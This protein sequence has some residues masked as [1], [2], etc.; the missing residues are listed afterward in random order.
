MISIIAKE[1]FSATEYIRILDERTRA[2]VGVIEMAPNAIEII[3]VKIVTVLLKSKTQGIL[4]NMNR[5]RENLYKKA[6]AQF[7]KINEFMR[8]AGIKCNFQPSGDYIVFDD[9]DQNPLNTD[10]PFFTIGSDKDGNRQVIFQDR[11]LVTP[12]EQEQYFAENPFDDDEMSNKGTSKDYLVDLFGRKYKAL[13]P[14]STFKG[15]MFFISE[16]AFV[17]RGGYTLTVPI[18]NQEIAVFGSNIDDARTYAHELG[19][20]LGLQHPFID[21]INFFNGSIRDVLNDKG[22]RYPD[23]NI[24]TLIRINEQNIKDIEE[25]IEKK[26]GEI[27][28]ETEQNKL[29][30][31]NK[32]LSSL[33]ERKGELLLEKNDLEKRKIFLEYRYNALFGQKIKTRIKTSANIMDYLYTTQE[34]EANPQLKED[35]KKKVL[36]SKKQCEIMRKEVGLY[37]TILPLLIVVFSLFSNI[38]FGQEY[39]DP[40]SQDKPIIVLPDILIK[41]EITGNKMKDTII[42]TNTSKGTLFSQGEKSKNPATFFKTMEEYH[43]FWLQNFDIKH[44]LYE[45]KREVL[46]KFEIWE[47]GRV[48]VRFINGLSDKLEGEISF[49]I[50]HTLG[51]CMGKWTPATDE[52]GKPTITEGYLI[53]HFDWEG[54]LK[55]R[56]HRVRY[57]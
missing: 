18:K 54:E 11:E 42:V 35:N 21:D 56:D 37:K 49:K 7:D 4:E 45:I 17:N 20:L 22:I 55:R 40:I 52:E 27:D 9:D 14:N 51:F 23:T 39:Y 30:S 16:G 36:F 29:F 41:R 5:Q 34:I 13:H 12:S 28:K 44:Y 3:E 1:T 25:D 50:H 43:Q 53:I 31:L 2:T 6:E 19:H 47:D 32:E 8:Q 24:D 26:Q 38:I 10:K 46:V 48:S 33:N 57:F 15:V